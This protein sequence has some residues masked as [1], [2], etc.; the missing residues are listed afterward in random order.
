MT[1]VGPDPDAQRVER[2]ASQVQDYHTVFGTPEGQKVL[3]DILDE[4]GFISDGFNPDPYVTAHSCGKRAVA[5]FILQKMELS[6]DDVRR[7]AREVET[8]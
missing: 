3:L 5:C 8:Y 1:K 7:M 2:I 6:V 4:A